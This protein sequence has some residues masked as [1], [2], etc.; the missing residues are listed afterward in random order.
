M[1]CRLTTHNYSVGKG[2]PAYIFLPVAEQP[3]RI[4]HGQGFHVFVENDSC[5]AMRSQHFSK[6]GEVSYMVI[7][8]QKCTSMDA[9]LL[10]SHSVRIPTICRS[11]CTFY[12]CHQASPFVETEMLVNYF[13]RNL[14][15]DPLRTS[16]SS[17]PRRRRGAH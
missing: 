2:A 6:D 17:N 10:I 14:A 15:R 16:N 8:T 4:S 11:P 9:A 13:L 12:K 3:S 1:E 7:P 5:G